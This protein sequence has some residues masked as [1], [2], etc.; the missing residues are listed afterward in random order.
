MTILFALS[1][2]LQAAQET[3]GVTGRVL[4]DGPPPKPKPI[5]LPGAEG[6]VAEDLVVA[7]DGGVANA[8]ITIEGTGR[9]DWKSQGAAIAFRDGQI[10]PRVVFVSPGAPLKVRNETDRRENAHPI[11]F[12]NKERNVGLPPGGSAEISFEKPERI[13]LKC[14]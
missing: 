1:L 6:L 8:I 2:A 10:R 4:L 9:A 14:G 13:G 3:G 7:K 11:P 12:E 5:K